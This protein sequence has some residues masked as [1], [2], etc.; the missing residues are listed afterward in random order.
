MGVFDVPTKYLLEAIS[1]D[2]KEKNKVQKPDFADFV[3]TGMYAERAPHDPDWWYMRCSSILYRVFK[4][5]PVGTESLRTYYGG[6]KNRGSRPTRHRKAGGKIIRLALQQ[7]ENNKLIKKNQKKGRVI[8]PE[9]Q[10]YLNE[11]SKIALEISKNAQPK[12]REF[13]KGIRAKKETPQMKAK[14]QEKEKKEEKG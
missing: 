3:K 1:K 12:K 8:T 7:L 10:K 11:M 4:D 5:G 9:G 13:K 6:R 14:K 2:F